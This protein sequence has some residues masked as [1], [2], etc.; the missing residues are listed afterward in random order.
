[1]Q[2]LAQELFQPE[3]LSLALVGPYDDPRPFQE[4]LERL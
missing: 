2:E 4:L 3:R 1:V